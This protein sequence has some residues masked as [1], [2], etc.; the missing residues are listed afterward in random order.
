MYNRK[1]T[2]LRLYLVDEEHFKH[3]PY[4]DMEIPPYTYQ[5]TDN[6]ECWVLYSGERVGR[7]V[8][9]KCVGYIVDFLN[10]SDL[11]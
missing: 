4:P 6:G 3:I 5:N 10:S 2:Q 1:Y 7:S 9:V 8:K 11:R